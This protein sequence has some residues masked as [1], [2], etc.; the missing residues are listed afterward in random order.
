MARGANSCSFRARMSNSDSFAALFETEFKG[1]AKTR[2]VS[3]GESVEGVV[4]RVGKE[5]VFVELD[6]KRQA[7]FDAAELKLPDGTMSV[8]EGQTIEARV[9]SVDES[10]DVKLGRTMGKPN[11]LAALETAK[12][13]RLAIDGKVTGFNKGGLEVDVQGARAFCPNSQIDIR[14]V[15]DPSQFVGQSLRFHITEIRDGGKS[16]VL[17][18]RSILDEEQRL[19]SDRAWST[20]QVGASLRGTVTGVREFGAFVDLGGVEGLI[21][22]QELSHERGQ[23]ATDVVNPGDVVEVLVREIKDGKTAK[24]EP[25]K[26]I[27]LSLKALQADPWTASGASLEVGKVVSGT[28]TRIADFGLFVRVAPGIDGLLHVSELGA[29]VEHPSQAA[30]V[31]DGIHV[32][33]RKVDGATQRVE[34]AAAP[35]GASVGARVEAPSFGIGAL[36]NGVVEKIETFGIFI[37]IEG[38]KGRSGRGL[39]P[40]AELG[41]PRGSDTRKHFPEGTKVVAKILETSEG[42]LRLSLRA[43]KDD[44]ERAD[45]DGYRAKSSE[46]AKLGTFA[47][48]LKKR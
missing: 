6:G 30:K 4:V 48:L 40:N 9:I 11:N 3:V 45:F 37:Q 5:A 44:E 29:K 2:R 8:A 15:Q 43:V 28:V 21:P 18:R 39:V 26:R 7:Y 23:K 34:L 20:I 31:G 32:V 12:E 1:T 14:F 24:G 19:L 13:A 46:T 10:G 17:S 38:T 41:T 35:E 42:R 36:V 22:N 27:T 47:D 33:I 25:Q 16:I